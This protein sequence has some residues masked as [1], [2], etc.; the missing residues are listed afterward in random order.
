V[1]GKH[2]RDM[3]RAAE[4]FAFTDREVAEHEAVLIDDAFPRG[5][6]QDGARGGRDL[7]LHVGGDC[8]DAEAARILAAAAV[9]W[10]TR[11]GGKVW[12]FTHSWRSVPAEAWGPIASLASCENTSDVHKAMARGYAAALVVAEFPN[13][14]RAFDVGDGVKAIP[15]PAETRGTT[16]VQ[17]RL[18]LDQP[19]RE[20]KRAVAFKV[21]GHTAKR[22]REALK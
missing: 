3:D 22:A 11:G 13:G 9:R 5:V 7:R 1:T 20:L 2:L 8:K 6:P 12:T 10:R 17:C 14:D 15:C 21:H 4:A 16:C 18:C 19:L